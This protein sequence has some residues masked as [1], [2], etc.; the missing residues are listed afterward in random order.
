MRLRNRMRGRRLKL[1]VL[2]RLTWAW[3]CF[4][5]LVSAGALYAANDGGRTSAAVAMAI[6]EVERLAQPEPRKAADAKFDRLER[7]AAGEPASPD[8]AIAGAAITLAEG[9]DVEDALGTISDLGGVMQASIADEVVITI[10]GTPARNSAEATAGAALAFKPIAAPDEALLKRSAYGRIPRISADGRKPS[11]FYAQ[12]FTPDGRPIAALIVGGLG[13]NRALTERA[14]DELPP[15]VTLAFAPYAK[16]LPFWTKRAREA[17]H[18]VMI[19]LPME[20]RGGDVSALGPAALLTSRSPDENLQ[21]LDWLLSR[22]EGYFGVTNYLGSKFAADR[23]AMGPVLARL[24]ASGLS[25]VDDTGALSGAKR[26]GVASVDRFVN[27]GFR[28]DKSETSRDL[29]TLEKTAKAN[30]DALG[31]TYVHDD[32]LTIVTDWALALDDRGVSL[33]P[34]SAV[35]ALRAGDL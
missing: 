17:G 31:K 2:S 21:R 34:A 13:L 3:L 32:T 10:D 23:E 27:P 24:E 8:A 28:A 33:A 9:D 20:H 30:G 22:F 29:E 16:D 5:A 12:A 19:E 26:A 18:E 4:V 11:K 14:I 15:G 25:F 35:L 1:P 7:L 6:D